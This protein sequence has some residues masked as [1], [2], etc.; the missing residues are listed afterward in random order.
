[1]YEK[2]SVATRVALC[3]MVRQDSRSR[4]VYSTLRELRNFF[5]TEPKQPGKI[6]SPEVGEDGSLILYFYDPHRLL[7]HRGGGFPP[8]PIHGQF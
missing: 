4:E 5:L 1:M 3:K 6:L 2:I 7:W 8:S